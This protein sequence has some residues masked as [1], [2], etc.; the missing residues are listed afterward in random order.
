MFSEDDVEKM[1]KVDASEITNN[2]QDK[3]FGHYFND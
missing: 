1:K 3:V 2:I